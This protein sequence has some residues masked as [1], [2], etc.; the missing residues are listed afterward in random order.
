MDNKNVFS[1]LVRILFGSW[2]S[3]AGH[4]IVFFMI[5]VLWGDLLFFTTLVSIEAIYISIFILMAEYK[6]EQYRN[7][8]DDLRHKAENRLVRE[9]VDL[10][11]HV[12]SEITEIKEHQRLI[13]ESFEKI[14]KKLE[15]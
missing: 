6:E 2:Y 10:T 9:D 13:N 11:Q 12:I 7:H 15:S 3:V 8:L 14:R 1:D 5:L 4:T